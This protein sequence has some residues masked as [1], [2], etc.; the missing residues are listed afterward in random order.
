MTHSTPDVYYRARGFHLRSF[1]SSYLTT[2]WRRTREEAEQDI[3][4][5]G[6][7]YTN[8]RVVS[9]TAQEYADKYRK[10]PRTR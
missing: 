9:I 5:F 10:L 1:R 4:V 6:N 3:R 2:V 8:L 7:G